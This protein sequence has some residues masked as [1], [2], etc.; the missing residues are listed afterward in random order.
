LKEKFGSSPTF[1]GVPVQASK[2]VNGKLVN[3]FI[4]NCRCRHYSSFSNLNFTFIVFENTWSTSNCLC[5]VDHNRLCMTSVNHIARRHIYEPGFCGYAHRMNYS[6][7][8]CLNLRSARFGGLIYRL[9]YNRVSAS[10]NQSRKLTMQVTSSHS[11]RP[12]G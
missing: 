6:E 9:A 2:S 3:S 4:M 8:S 1:L 12:K 7:C 11:L 5:D 10:P